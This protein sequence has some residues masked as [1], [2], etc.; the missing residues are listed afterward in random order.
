MSASKTAPDGI[1]HELLALL[2]RD[3]RLSNK[4]LAARV[5]LAPSSCHARVQRLIEEG[6]LLGFH[7]ELNLERL[8]LGIQAM[9]RIQL[10][11]QWGAVE[12]LRTR[13]L[14]QP[15]VLELYHVSGSEDLLIRVAVRDTRQ[16]QTL[17]LER[18]LR[19][20]EARHVET[21][22][23]FEH[24]RSLELPVGPSPETA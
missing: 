11:Q 21:S 6:F 5:G 19:P 20:D 17:I 18:L 13:L 4:E 8:G 9:I 1:D 24:D 14:S 12:G 3:A 15:E 22:I 2:Q 23:I 7:A 10:Q 16:L